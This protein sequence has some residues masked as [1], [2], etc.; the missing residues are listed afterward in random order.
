MTDLTIIKATLKQHI[1]SHL[2]RV[3]ERFNN[4]KS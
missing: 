1:E 2:I 3:C 4:K